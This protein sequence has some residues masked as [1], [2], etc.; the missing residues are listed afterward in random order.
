VGALLSASRPASRTSSAVMSPRP[1]AA[2]IPAATCARVALWARST[3]WH[4]SSKIERSSAVVSEVN[5]ARPL[6]LSLRACF[7]FVVAAFTFVISPATFSQ[8][9]R[10]GAI[11]LRVMKSS[12]ALTDKMRMRM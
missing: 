6:L 1:A 7:L 12:A 5:M 8:S 2:N 11:D 10:N 3:S 4:T 9:H